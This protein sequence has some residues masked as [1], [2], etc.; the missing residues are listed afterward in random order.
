L[1][2][3]LGGQNTSSYDLTT[4]LAVITIGIE[5]GY[6]FVIKKRLAIDLIM[7]GP[8]VGYYSASFEGEGDIN[9]ASDEAKAVGDFLVGKFPGLGELVDTGSFSTSGGF[10][11]LSAGLR[12]AIQVGYVF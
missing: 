7:L 10:N 6:Q 1:S 12:F 11:V 9:L 2:D 3:S 8:G 4:K 5:L